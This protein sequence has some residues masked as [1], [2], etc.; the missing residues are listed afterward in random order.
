MQSIV[1]INNEG[2]RLLDAGFLERARLTFKDALEQTTE[3]LGQHRG[4]MD[5]S[6]CW[7]GDSTPSILRVPVQGSRRG[8]SK[9]SSGSYLYRY[10]LAVDTSNV[11][12]NVDSATPL[13]YQYSLRLTIVLMYNLGLVHHWRA[14][15]HY[16]PAVLV[17]ALRLYEM[18]WRLLQR[19]PCLAADPS[20]LGVLNNMGILYFDLAQYKES[21]HCF[22]M[23][24]SVFL[25][26]QVVVERE[27]QDGIMLNL[28]FLEEPQTAAAA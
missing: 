9:E 21:H 4:Q 2:V 27:V 17:K 11:G 18:T 10:A 14:L 24:R 12:S 15:I 22:D 6:S 23:L 28:L 16:E 19:S 26:N 20:L 1:D 8:F 7:S 5:E 25:N 13:D 3:T